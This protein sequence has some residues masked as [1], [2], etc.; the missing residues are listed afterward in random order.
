[1]KSINDLKGI[2]VQDV[3]ADIFIAEFANFLEKSG[4]FTVPVV[5][6]LPLIIY[7]VG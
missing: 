3:A 1:M 4:N 2:S 5:F 7:I 6:L